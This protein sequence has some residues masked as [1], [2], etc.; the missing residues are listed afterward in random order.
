MVSTEQYND[1]EEFYFCR[2]RRFHHSWQQI[3]ETPSDFPPAARFTAVSAHASLRSTAESLELTLLIKIRLRIKIKIKSKKGLGLHTTSE[4]YSV[5][6]WK[7]STRLP[8]PSSHLL[9]GC[10]S[11]ARSNIKILRPNPIQLLLKTT[12]NSTSQFWQKTAAVC[13]V[14]CQ[15]YIPISSVYMYCTDLTTEWCSDWRQH[16]T[17]FVSFNHMSSSFDGTHKSHETFGNRSIYTRHSLRVA[18]HLISLLILAISFLMKIV[19]PWRSSSVTWRAGKCRLRGNNTLHFM[20]KGE[21]DRPEST[22]LCDLLEL[23]KQKA[24][25]LPHWEGWGSN[26]VDYGSMI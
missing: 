26:L 15:G 7:Y 17:A 22:R 11:S 6:N 25:G 2:G 20:Q 23:Q 13:D 12:K 16:G 8:S 3:T 19:N 10:V 1:F 18:P 24:E 14:L 4:I 5:N 9:R 21:A